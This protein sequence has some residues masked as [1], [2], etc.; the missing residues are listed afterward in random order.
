MPTEACSHNRLDVLQWLHQRRYFYLL[1]SR[2]NIK[3]DTPEI[4]N[5][6]HEHLRSGAFPVYEVEFKSEGGFTMLQ[7]ASARGIPYYSFLTYDCIADKAAAA[8]HLVALQRIIAREQEFGKCTCA[9]LSL[10]VSGDQ[11][12]MVQW[13]YERY[14][15]AYFDELNRG[16]TNLDTIRWFFDYYE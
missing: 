14:P 2:V 11:L 1:H 5:W 7:L 16:S 10:A 12:D 13:L 9:A 15:A 4:A 8:G 6:A 3:Y